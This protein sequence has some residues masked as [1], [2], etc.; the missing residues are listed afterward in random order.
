MAVKENRVNLNEIFYKAEDKEDLFDKISDMIVEL[1]TE[2]N[3][4]LNNILKLSSKYSYTY[5]LI[6]CYLCLKKET[7]VTRKDIM[8]DTGLSYRVV[9]NCLKK[10][11]ELGIVDTDIKPVKGGSAYV[12][13]V[14]DNIKI[15]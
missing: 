3:N 11:R 6:Y 10:F 13:Y 8:D 9:S 5:G 14:K 12:Y 2:Y 4:T 7:G 1:I 15:Q